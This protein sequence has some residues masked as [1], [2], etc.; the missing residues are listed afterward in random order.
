MREYAKKYKQEVI[1]LRRE[2]HMNPEASLQEYNTSKIIKGTLDKLGI[3]YKS[4]AET[5]VIAEIKGKNPGKTIALRADMDALSVT[6]LNTCDFKSKNEGLMHACGHDCHVASLLGAAMVLNDIKDELNGTVKLLFQPGEEVALGAKNMIKDG[7]LEGVDGIFGMHVWGT[8][9]CGTVNIQEGPIMASADLFTI[10]VKG[11]GGHGS[12]PHQGIDA[13]LASSAIVMNLQS[14]VSREIDPLQPVVV[15]VGS[16]NAGSRFNVIASE[17]VLTGTTRCFDPKIRDNFPEIIER[18]IK[19]TACTYRA[20]AELQYTNGTPVV[21]NN[22]ECANIGK[23][24]LEKIG[25]KSIT[26]EK[27]MGGEDFA[28][29]ANMIPAAFA[30]VGV[31]NKSKDAWYPNHH[32]KFTVDEDGL[33]VGTALYAQYA[34]DFLSNV[35]RQHPINVDFL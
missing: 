19:E 16:L 27:I 28:E 30:L 15:S 10:N 9:E 11:K 3:P 4:I 34:V 12:A 23:K 24:S 14:I 21:I 8:L 32:P 25:V 26:I 29:Y 2:F 22:A 18:V 35:T 33:E 6:E 20:D 1:N 5:G 13:V 17:G 7:A 31:G